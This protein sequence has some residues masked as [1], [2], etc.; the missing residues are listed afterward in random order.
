MSELSKVLY[1]CRRG[2]KELDLLT[3]K[4]ATHYFED[5]S[6]MERDAFLQLLE[7]QDPQLYYLLVE[8]EQFDDPVIRTIVLKIRDLST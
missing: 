1:R 4:Y 2:T 5:A 7:L 8:Q 3:Q 6:R